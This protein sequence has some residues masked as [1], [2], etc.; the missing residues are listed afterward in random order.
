MNKRSEL[1]Y[2]SW[3]DEQPRMSK[4]DWLFIAYMLAGANLSF[5]IGLFIGALIC[6]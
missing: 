6:L 2:L 3:L 4:D 1:F 5:G